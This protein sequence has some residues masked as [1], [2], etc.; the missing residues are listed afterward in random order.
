MKYLQTF[1]ENI[2]LSLFSDFESDKVF[3]NNNWMIIK[4]KSYQ[5]LLDLSEDTEWRISNIYSNYHSVNNFKTTQYKMNDYIYVNLNKNGDKYLFDFY[6]NDF[7]DKEDNDVYLKDFF[8][9]NKDLLNYYGEV[10]DC[11]NIVKDGNDYWIVNEEGNEWFSDFY[12]ENRD[13]RKDFIKKILSGDSYELF[14]YFGDVDLDEYGIKLDDDSLILMKT[15][16]LLYKESNDDYDYDITE[17]DDYDDV[18]DIVEEYDLDELKNLLVRSITN[19]KQSADESEAF[20]DVTNSFYN[21]FN[22]VNGSAKWQIY[23]RSKSNNQHLWIKFKSKEDA[24]YA[25]FRILNYDDSYSDDLIDY[26][27]PYYGYSGD[28]KVKNEVFNSELFGI[29]SEE[30]HEFDSNVI[31]DYYNLWK[32]IKQNEPDMSEDDIIERI[33]LRMQT[34]KYNI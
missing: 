25:K 21:F 28:D 33:K 2:Q 7:I 26:S 11:Y 24:Y 30:I 14:E 8:D 31:D 3:E 10:I 22:L 4:P 6:K 19:G 1:K 20:E 34:K 16:L 17:V 23:N 12:K 15:I 18:K 5:T 9:N 29:T 13:L 27:P 32:N